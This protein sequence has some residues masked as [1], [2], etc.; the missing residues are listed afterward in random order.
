MTSRSHAG[1][2]LAFGPDGA[3]YVSIGD[4]TSFDITDPR[5]F[6]V[7][8]LNSLS[9]KVLRIDPA[10]GQ[11]LVDNPFVEPGMSLDLN[12]AKVYQLGL[13]N[14]FSMTFDEA[15]RILITETGWNLW[16][17]INSGGPGANYG[18]P[19]YEG[20]DG[21]QIIRAPGYDQLAQS[22]AFYPLVES[23]QVTLA[24]AFRAFSHDG[25][26]PGFQIQ[27]ITGGN[28]IYS[29]GAD[30]PAALIG[31]Y[32]FTDFVDGE[33]YSV[34]V[35]DRRDVTYLT[36]TPSFGPA[37]YTIGPDGKVYYVDL[38]G[39]S[40][41]RLNI[42]DLDITP[43]SFLSRGAATFDPVTTI[44]TLTTGTPNVVGA[45]MSTTR[46]DVREDFS[47][48]FELNFGTSD[49]GGH[50]AAFI[51]H[52][53]TSAFNAIGSSGGSLGALGIRKGLAVTFDTFDN[54]GASGDIASDHVDIFD[55]DGIA[56][57]LPFSVANLEDGVFHTANVAWTAAT[58]TLDVTLD[59]NTV[60]VFTTSDLAQSFLGNSPFAYFGFTASTG[61]GPQTNQQQLRLGTVEV[62]YEAPVGPNNPPAITSDGGSDTAA[63]TV[64][65]NQTAV[66]TVAAT[67]PD[68][69]D[70]VLYA[71]AG[72]ADAARFQI[73]FLSGALSFITPPDFEAPLDNGAD[74]T[75][76]V[77]IEATDGNGGADS[78][79]IAVTISDV[80][81]ISPPPSD[82]A[83]QTGTGED[84]VLTGLGG[85]NFLDGLAG[86]DSL[87]GGGGNDTLLGGDGNDTLDGGA[88]FGEDV[89]SLYGGQGND[90]LIIGPDLEPLTILDGG[91]GTDRLTLVGAGVL[92]LN[93]A[94]TI[95]SIEE[96]GFD[97]TDRID[98][99]IDHALL[100]PSI[101]PALHVFGGAF[102]D[103]LTI[104]GNATAPNT[105]N[106]STFTFTSW[107]PLQGDRIVL[108]GGEGGDTLTGSSSEN[109]LAGFGD[110]DSLV[111]GTS[112]DLID[113]GLGNDTSTGGNGI[114]F[115]VFS[116]YDPLAAQAD[117][118]TDFNVLEDRVL[119][120]EN[121]P[122]S[123]TAVVEGLLRDDG[124]GLAILSG[125]FNGN[126]QTMALGVPVG[127][128]NASHF[129][130]ADLATPRTVTGSDGADLLFGSLGEDTITAGGGADRIFGDEGADQITGAGGDDTI[131]G[132]EGS[133]TVVLTGDRGDY[134]FTASPAGVVI[135]DSVANRD[136][137]D[138]IT[139][140][141]FVTFATGGP[142]ALSDVLSDTTTSV[143]ITAIEGGDDTINA[144]EA[145]GGILVSGTAEVG[146]TLTVNGATVAVDTL[147]AWSTTLAAPVADG[148]LLVTAAVTDTAGNTASVVR[149]LAI[150]TTPP[151]VAITSAGGTV[152][153]AAQTI[154][155]TGEAGTTVTVLDGTTVLTTATVAANGTWSAAVTLTG[156][157]AHSLTA[158]NTDAAGNTATSATVA[159]VLDTTAP[160]V[161][162]TAIEGG[163]DTINAAEAAGGILVSGTA[164][165]GATLTVN[166]ATV[167]VDTLGA[168]STTL[169]A[170]VADGPLLVTA[171][172]TDTAGNTA[173]VVRTLAIDTTPPAVAITSAG[174]TVNVAAQTIAGTGEAG[175]TVTVLDGTTVLTTAT[176]AANGTW[177]AAVT[178]TG[179]GAHSLT[180]TN[181]DAA[182]N[183]ATSATVAFVLDTTAPAVAI[184]AIE[185]GDDTINAAEAAG[186]ILV[187]GTAEVGATLT[188]NGATVA[189]DT[190]GAW[191]TT[192]AAPVADGPLLVTA[193]VTDTAGNTASVVRTLAI[194]TT[195]PAVAITSAGGTVNVA[196]QTIA[197]T[198]E[199][200][201]TVTVLDGTTV[202]TTA[203]V[204]ANGT[205]SAAVTLTGEGAH[206]LTATNTDAAGNTAT[207]A[208]VA[209]VLDTT[210][211]AV[212]IT[213]IEGGDD[214]INAAE[215]A[216]G[217][218]VS[219]TAEVGATLT[220]NG[221]TVAVDTLGAWSTTLAAPVADGPL[222]VTAAVTDTAGNT[223][224]VVRTLAIDTTP[225]AVAITSAGG[226][227]NVAA[228][229]IAG[230]GE[231]GTTVT[232]LDGTTVLTTATV[233]ANG[234]WS[235][236]VTL[237]GEGAHSLTATN[238]DAAGNTATS[239]TV[240]FVLDTTAP[241]VAITAIEGGDDTINA[242][243]AAGG[244]L[245]SGTAEVGATLTVNGATVAVDTLGAWSTTLA[246]PVAD[247]PLLVTAAVTDTA[248][249]TASVVRTL[250]IDT[251][252]PAVAI[253]SAGG[254]VNVAA[255]TI[256]GTG[257]AGTTVTVLD[258]TTVLTTATVAANGTWSAAVTLTG[259]GAHSLT[260]T[261]TDAAGNTATS[262]TVA[263]VLDTTAPAVAIT[264]IEG[265]DD[266]INAAEAAGGILVS[267][268][269]EVGATLTV[270]GA[271]VAVDTLGAWS[272]TLAAPVADGPL[273]VTAAVTDTAGNTAS[274][275]RTLA[276]DTTP[277]AVA[278][279]SAG[280]TV[281]V[282]AQTIAGTGEA[283]TTVTVL[284]GTTVL[285]TAT[286]AANGTWSAAVTLTGEGA[287]SLTATNTDAAGN[288]AT[289]AT[290]AFVLDTNLDPIA[291]DDAAF[292]TGSDA[293]PIDVLAN[294][295]DPEGATLSI[296]AAG[297]GLNGVVTIDDNGT[298]LVT[299]DDFVVYRPNAGFTGP[300]DQ[301][302][303]TISDGTNTASANVNVTVNPGTGGGV[304]AFEDFE[305]GAVG[306]TS[307]TTT[308]GG[309]ALTQFLGRFGV[310]P[311]PATQ[312]TFA[313]P[314]GVAA[315]TLSFDFY[316]IDS[317]DGAGGWDFLNLTINDTPVFMEGFQHANLQG[318]DA[319]DAGVRTGS[320]P[321][322]T[323]T[324][325]PVT[326]GGTSLGFG[327]L[328]YQT[329]QIHHVEVVIDNPGT[330]LKVGFGS[331][332]GSELADESYGIDNVRIVA[333]GVVVD[334][335]PTAVA[336][337][338][339][340]LVDT[341]VA[342]A[343]LAND[344]DPEGAALSI[345]AV[346]NGLNGLVAINDNGTPL[347]TGDD[348]VVYTPN[349]G[350]NGPSDQ[351]S[352]T[353]SDGANTA[354][355]T[356]S[357]TVG[358]EPVDLP[359]TAVADVAT[360]LVGTPVAIAV[361]ANDSDP[362]GA[363]LS[364]VAAENGLNG[365]VAI[366]DNGTPL[367][368]GDDFVV[369]TPNAGFTGPSDQFSYIISDGANTATAT[370]T[371]AV[372]TEPVDLP[373]TAV[374]DVAATLAGT[375]VAIEV[376]AN[377]SD[378]EGAA[379]SIVAA[380]NG[381]NGLVTIDDNGTPL[382]SGDDFVVYTPNAG[383]TGPSDQFS[384]TI[385]D[386]TNTASATV[387]VTV[388]SG[389]GGGVIAFEDFETGA[390]GWTSNT[391]TDGGAALTQ[392]LG[393]FGVGPN[394]ATQKTFAL[395]AGVSAVT[396]SFDFYEIDSW[397]GTSGWD[398]LN[399]TINDTPV[400]MEA[401]QHAN[402]QG[403][404]AV[405]AAVR[406]G[407]IP[408]MAWTIT[409]VTDGGS[410]LGFGSA[411]YQ[412]DQI[413]H[414]EVV[415]EN[416][417][418]S[419]TVGFG[420]TLGSDLT[421]ESYG[422]DNVR[423]VADGAV[424]DLPPTAVA[425]VATTLAGTPVAIAVLA[426]D[427]DPEG[428]ALSIVAAGNGLNGVVTI[429]DNGTPLVSS[430][431]F[432][433]Y[434]PNAGFTG[435]SDQFSYTIS[436]GT[437]T[438]SATVDVTV[439]AEP[440]DLPPTAVADVATTLAGTPVAIAV[441]ANDSDPESA[442]L[443]I[444]AAGNGL[445]GVV[446]IDDNGT[447]LV[448]GDDFVV[449]TPNAGFTGPSDQFSYTISDGT[450]T[451]SA[452][453]SVSVSDGTGG[454]VLVAAEDFE[455]GAIG[456][457][458][459]TTTDGGAVL[460]EFL[461]RF[462]VGGDPATQKT[463]ALPAGSGSA[464]LSF[465]FYEIDSWDGTGGWDFLNLTVN[466][467]L[468]FM[469]AFQHA[470]LQGVNAVD[471]AVRTGTAPG[472]SWTITPVTSGGTS[473]GFG[474]AWYQTDQIHHVEVVIDDPGA[475]LK[476]E[477]ASTLGS[478]LSDESYGI[479]NLQV[480]ADL[481]VS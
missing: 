126:P 185:G 356:V 151:A 346:E 394:P 428:A 221:A 371:V 389:T 249:N 7:Q 376:L 431:D 77:I 193:A 335:P 471:A 163:D 64:S 155:G 31:D 112:A 447:P 232:V 296:V 91:P 121:G 62:T 279:T 162:I 382:V 256:A 125:Q 118:V 433:V 334:L 138:T 397:D 100:G 472:M 199:A 177:S 233:A 326:D 189:V 43:Q 340:T 309:A 184:T 120:I 288:T 264:A 89:D 318:V 253:T 37:H 373:P 418:A 178:L 170:P 242:A 87:S 423:I 36:T 404:D 448:S 324:I 333:D 21:G 281:N 435:P 105:I 317:W 441:L 198:G 330:D 475:S 276:I 180:A 414:V 409:P 113:G 179:E 132:G 361:L 52:N 90:N 181:T 44:Y 467:T 219:G 422:I 310:G 53:D 41:G 109:V 58:Q 350:F 76:D 63:L 40:I 363:A 468:V 11:G 49:S 265:G 22:Q 48:S 289:S 45:V 449:Y 104:Q 2:S 150:D 393:R 261:N 374:A 455:G 227:V 94:F 38:F 5:S 173:S 217:I 391:T 419:L 420:S 80:T 122:A 196:A 167:A 459:N 299:G 359:P 305:T 388:N 302:S 73:D 383:F 438:A 159:F 195:P 188:V 463:F 201:T 244:I 301:F 19:Y 23:G 477:F 103:V 123:F 15:G 101:A 54:G 300:T 364:I 83:V 135:A 274:V 357:V 255:Q 211:P 352:Y 140:I 27:A 67:D 213:A 153:V 111:G 26:A 252:P 390:V 375:P 9:G 144:A 453:V 176:V 450:N 304:I 133:D 6:D 98:L 225:P 474:S 136:G 69:G 392:F 95:L 82:D 107:N 476:V 479:D 96:I 271:T 146:A 460:T 353:I 427:S 212:A 458:S 399:L 119:F 142:I 417:G 336:D 260:A 165:V 234:T 59:G 297:N 102:R 60:S 348:F 413:H 160:A 303:Y 396:L 323:W 370:V 154:A 214:T 401:F 18:W 273:L 314:A 114:D 74:N 231:A 116:A 168:W 182:G 432:V 246:A 434:T 465:D 218:L 312:K 461:G 426:N 85:P 203:T 362:E 216:G 341:P 398:F 25:T 266:T 425:D 384:Y 194:D 295:S 480:Y 347:V 293:V 161:A 117:V 278:I 108:I 50:G 166:G 251:T 28:A 342:V 337:V 445:N 200:G 245:V 315:V 451:A 128:L 226:T 237:T 235:A 106:A 294:D 93:A 70:T 412:T 33:I 16:E 358:S 239:A 320:I 316:E 386:G 250:A 206:S 88:Q 209:F 51:L 411:W 247:G 321:G 224:S 222:L 272:T 35:N 344:S 306:W 259:E 230:T 169:A 313:L 284:D 292:V 424:V 421:D 464:T 46:L 10:T 79:A 32:F 139:D 241:A 42:S 208:T 3:L 20:G 254:T 328:W 129:V 343:V 470:N 290:V 381:L 115:H 157:G 130:Y 377:D 275:V 345:V 186:G 66:T 192:L 437:N 287:H 175:T 172:V 473:L 436:D 325:T 30:Y 84:D 110:A 147:G 338:A 298:P 282:A 39:G 56:Q 481:L 97:T 131:N 262:A 4:G 466:D 215:A 400:F 268:T 187:S 24:P 238:T 267:G 236:A 204:A 134:T 379:L 406:T 415:I 443:S 228:Q 8:N 407:S 457:S 478:E 57:T 439:N 220:V 405:D 92:T 402:L 365:L 385:S 12:Q 164:E 444:V 277:P 285:T 355:A 174:G 1:G 354:T 331:T 207:S 229:T 143:A 258:G 55:T 127:A 137:T 205:W 183:T 145:A 240:A 360:T 248:G 149:T 367:V 280:G 47:I 68:A 408:G 387:D 283:G 86:N 202:L 319:V 291:V 61:S 263:F 223:A 171:A 349:A 34:D 469:E 307:N 456:W 446:T 366:N 429:D 257:E 197:G 141:E 416:P 380:G 14:P 65:E 148:P 395:P 152:N 124:T 322:M 99:N 452:T 75:Y 269:A 13:R 81:G 369:Y 270:N 403:V 462:G 210:A 29:G 72:G 190:L 243:E 430:D 71:I 372:N 156:E 311:N 378:P 339:T 158:T 286:V 329:D 440:V 191:S 17:E 442:A 368:T 454:P 308:D 78:Q 410:S 351:F 327:N 332:L